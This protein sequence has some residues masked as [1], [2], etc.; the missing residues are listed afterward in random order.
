MSPNIGGRK[1]P[2]ERLM[3]LSDFSQSK[4]YCVLVREYCLCGFSGVFLGNLFVIKAVREWDCRGNS[5]LKKY[6]VKCALFWFQ[7]R[8]KVRGNFLPQ[9]Y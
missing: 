4:K 9:F 1:S 5:E 3:G 2:A 6:K 7:V 8:R